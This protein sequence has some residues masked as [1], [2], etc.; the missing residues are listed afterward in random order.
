[1]ARL[2]MLDFMLGALGSHWRYLDPWSVTMIQGG[3]GLPFFQASKHKP[4]W[5]VTHCESNWS[6]HP[7]PPAST[8][9]EMW[10]HEAASH[11]QA[12]VSR[13]PP[14]ETASQASPHELSSFI[15]ALP[16]VPQSRPGFFSSSRALPVWCGWGLGWQQIWTETELCLHPGFAMCD[17]QQTS[18]SFSFLLENR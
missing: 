9:K 8:Q 3:F 11:P 15:W 2:K 7:T 5:E 6:P 18:L 16:T 12:L 4:S 14:P 10:A 13:R 1:M 17:L